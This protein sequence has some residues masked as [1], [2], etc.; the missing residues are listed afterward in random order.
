LVS[1]LKGTH[2]VMSYADAENRGGLYVARE[3]ILV[4]LPRVSKFKRLLNPI[5][6]GKVLCGHAAM[7]AAIDLSIFEPR[8]DDLG[9][10]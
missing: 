5:S 8:D 7:A 9:E 1:F 6:P 4:L 2:S 10:R 3:E